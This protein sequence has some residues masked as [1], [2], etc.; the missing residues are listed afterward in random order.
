MRPQ[1]EMIP[2]GE[3]AVAAIRTVMISMSPLLRELGRELI[4]GHADLDVVEALDR[5]DELREQLRPL[6]PDVI[7]IGLGPNE[8]DEIGPSLVRFLPNTKVIAF[9]SDMRRAF[10]HS[11]Q[12]HTVWPT[13]APVSKVAKNA[14]RS[15]RSSARAALSSTSVSPNGRS[16]IGFTIS[17]NS[18]R[19]M[20]TLRT[21][22][23]VRQSKGGLLPCR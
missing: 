14:S 23:A 4:A 6:A 3:L 10:V 1:L 9:S 16:R 18:V 17:L 21:H 13:A 2:A 8:G 5:R 22:A 11:I 7:F 15:T 12:E 19:I 20:G